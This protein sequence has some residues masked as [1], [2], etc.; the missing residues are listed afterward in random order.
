MN[1]L[2][3]LP[4]P[5]AEWLSYP[6][7]CEFKVVH[8]PDAKRVSEKV[9]CELCI[10]AGKAKLATQRFHH[11]R[12]LPYCK[13]RVIVVLTGLPIGYSVVVALTGLPIGY[14]LIVALIM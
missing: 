6:P 2:S 13:S 7:V 8:G 12:L 4:S 1:A 5:Q 11:E 10:A 9:T 14:T 3:V